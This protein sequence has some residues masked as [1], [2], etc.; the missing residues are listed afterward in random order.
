MTRGAAHVSPCSAVGLGAGAASAQTPETF[1]ALEYDVASVDGACP[2]ETEF[3][4]NVGRQL[5][6]DPFRADADKRVSVEIKRTANGLEGRMKWSDA[7]GRFAG[8]R[9]FSSHK[10]A[11]AELASSMT[12]S[13]AVQIQL[14]AS[15]TPPPSPPARP[16]A[17]SSP[18]ATAAAAPG[19]STS[20][21]AAPAP[22]PAAPASAAP[23]RPPSSPADEAQD[24]AATAIAIEPERVPATR[25]S[26]PH[27]AI[28][29]GFGAALA[30]GIAPAP[31][32]LARL[33]LGARRGQ[34]SLELA[35]DATLPVTEQQPEGNA[36]ALDTQAAD[37]I[38]CG[39]LAAFA[40]CVVGRLGRIHARGSGVD[41]PRSPSGLF[42]QAGARLAASRDLGD[43]FFAGAHVDGL[44]M[45]STWT[46]ALNGSAVWTTPRVGV[47][48]GV[49]VGARLF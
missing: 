35:A 33:F 41:A 4:R 5:G 20:A 22:A 9:R 25:S 13:A 40:G 43:R 10:P 34:L 39:H 49:D 2:T 3:R 16:A 12:F 29:A 27:V 36:F 24:A 11:C 1:V 44:V 17:P 42:A 6:Y 46:V 23:V 37:V 21:P 47:L 48:F 8:D 30:V 14:L 15:L 26:S 31:G 18:G 7:E 32:A 19:A 45:L 38:A 28:G